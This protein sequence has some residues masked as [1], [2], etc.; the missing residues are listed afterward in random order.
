MIDAI[1]W[2]VSLGRLDVNTTVM[3]LASFG[4]EPRQGHLER[5]KRVVSY[6]AKFK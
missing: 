4:A 6:L 5:C 1:Q 2:D 3:T